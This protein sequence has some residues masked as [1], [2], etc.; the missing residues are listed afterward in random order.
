MK[1]NA[2]EMVARS[3]PVLII[4]ALLAATSLGLALRMPAALQSFRD[5]YAAM[6]AELESRRVIAE[7]A[8]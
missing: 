2:D 5:I 3:M 6:G 7:R 8:W 1:S 4:A